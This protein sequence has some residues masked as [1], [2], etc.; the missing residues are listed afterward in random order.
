MMRLTRFLQEDA[1]QF[2]ELGHDFFLLSVTLG[3]DFFLLPVTLGRD[4]FL[5][6]VTPL[7]MCLSYYTPY[8]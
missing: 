1:L 6:P 7:P 4:F 5:L 2:L 8:P 3:H